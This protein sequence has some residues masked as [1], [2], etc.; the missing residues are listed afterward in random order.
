MTELGAPLFVLLT[1]CYLTFV[2]HAMKAAING[3]GVATWKRWVIASA[4][5]NTVGTWT[6]D[7]A[8]RL[9][10]CAWIFCILMAAD[11]GREAWL[12]AQMMRRHV[13]EVRALRH[14]VEQAE[15]HVEAIYVLRYCPVVEA[16]LT[17]DDCRQ[18]NDVSLVTA[19]PT[20][21][22]DEYEGCEVGE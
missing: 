21:R 6:G 3:Y 14:D 19:W 11:T 9:V 13:S 17:S 7:D 2:A 10:L 12:T 8:H 20:A 4:V 16:Q 18:V 22:I 1:L 5:L 15:Q